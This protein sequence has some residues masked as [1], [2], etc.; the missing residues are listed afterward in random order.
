MEDFKVVIINMYK[1]TKGILF[2]DIKGGMIMSN[3]MVNVN[4]EVF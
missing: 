1:R 3:Q 4:K 2:K